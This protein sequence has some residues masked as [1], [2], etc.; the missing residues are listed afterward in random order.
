MKKK[1]KEVVDICIRYLILVLVAVP[2][3]YLFYFIFTPLTILIPYYL[4]N[5]FLSAKLIGNIILIGHTPIQ[6]I[7]ACIA[8]SAYY[9]MLI[10]NL[11][12]PNIKIKKRF[13]ILFFCFGSFLLL[14]IIRILSLSLIAIHGYSWFDLAHKAFWYFGSVVFIIVIWFSS[15]KIFKI[16]EIPIFSDIVYL[17]KKS[18]LR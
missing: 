7:N 6:I 4:L 1:I 5:F 9:L 3:L 11:S 2:N 12:T 15:V 10:L 14:N 8:G 16:K 18:S 13:K 17:Y